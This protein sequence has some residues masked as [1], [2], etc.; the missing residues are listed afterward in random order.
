MTNQEE[1][2]DC[3]CTYPGCPRHA[4]CDACKSYH[5]SQ[6]QKTTCER[7]QTS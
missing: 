7:E 1:K 4:D 6:G 5:H 2:K 3:P